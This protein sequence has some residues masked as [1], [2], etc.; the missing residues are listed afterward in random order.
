M[1]TTD[2]LSKPVRLGAMS[3]AKV[4]RALL[5]GPCSVRELQTISGLSNTTLHEYMRALRKEQVVHICAWEKDAT[6]RESLRVFKLGAGKDVPRGKKTKAQV[7][8]ECRK[9]KQDA[10]LFSLFSEKPAAVSGIH[11]AKRSG[12]ANNCLHHSL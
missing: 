11:R 1:Q 5:D 9:R 2:D 3:M 6:G 8:R 7:A 12:S 10:K 4:T